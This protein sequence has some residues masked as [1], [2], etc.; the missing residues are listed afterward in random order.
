MTAVVDQIA[1]TLGVSGI[2]IVRSWISPTTSGVMTQLWMI[3]DYLSF[4]IIW[5]NPCGL[6]GQ[7]R[8]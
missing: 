2:Q 6:H 5:T 7:P 8:E 1:D 3:L 4:D